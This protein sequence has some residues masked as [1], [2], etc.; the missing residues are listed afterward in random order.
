M[1]ATQWRPRRSVRR[2]LF[3]C[4]NDAI[5][6]QP[7]F[8]ETILHEPLLPVRRG[9]DE[10]ADASVGP[11]NDLRATP[12][13]EWWSATHRVGTVPAGMSPSS[14]RRTYSPNIGSTKS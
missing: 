3:V 1:S 14:S 5:R 6:C 12:E 4:Q 13:I 7:E 11:E 10:L 8:P 9:T 2:G